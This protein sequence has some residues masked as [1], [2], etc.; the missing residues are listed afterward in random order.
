MSAG[1]RNSLARCSEGPPQ[2]IGER[3]VKA[4][5]PNLRLGWWPMDKALAA[6]QS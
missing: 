1:P 2:P 5:C 4:I 6:R 3:G